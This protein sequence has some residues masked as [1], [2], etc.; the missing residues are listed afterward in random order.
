MKAGL[1]PVFDDEP[2]GPSRRQTI[3]DVVSK[4]GIYKGSVQGHKIE[5]TE[6]TN[7]K[8][9]IAWRVRIRNEWRGGY[10]A[11][12]D[13]ARNRINLLLNAALMNRRPAPEQQTLF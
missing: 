4:E 3:I 7:P 13:E 6:V 1:Q 10:A 12:I 9:C 8:H 5:I 11:T 2:I